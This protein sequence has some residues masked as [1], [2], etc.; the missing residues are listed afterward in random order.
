MVLNGNAIG[1]AFYRIGLHKQFVATP[2][3]PANCDEIVSR[4]AD[5]IREGDRES[6]NADDQQQSNS[7]VT[8]MAFAAA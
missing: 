2:L 3:L 7:G 1:S 6:G 5:I 4:A 8:E